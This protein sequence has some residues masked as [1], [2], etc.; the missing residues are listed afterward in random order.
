MVEDGF[1]FGFSQVLHPNHLHGTSPEFLA[2]WASA[3]KSRTVSEVGSFGVATKASLKFRSKTGG[4][5]VGSSVSR[6]LRGAYLMAE[7]EVVKGL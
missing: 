6:P 4:P 1:G 3:G 7:Y 5:L 2:N